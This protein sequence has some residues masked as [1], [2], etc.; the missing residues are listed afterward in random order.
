MDERME[1]QAPKKKTHLHRKPTAFERRVEA[2]ALDQVTKALAENLEPAP[3]T[4]SDA[5]SPEELAPVA[6]PKQTQP[7]SPFAQALHIL[8]K[9]DL[10]SPKAL[11]LLADL[12][13]QAELERGGAPTPQPR[14]SHLIQPSGGGVPAPDL[15]GEYERRL[16]TLR[17]GDV[18]GLMELKRE[19]RKKGLEIY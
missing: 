19:F 2:R 5:S 10:S 11:R 14:A 18:L 16:G 4:D 12:A 7:E 8:Q 9:A 3:L 15:R 1:D 6:G 17:P 13:E